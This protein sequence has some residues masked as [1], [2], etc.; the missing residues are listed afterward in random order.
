MTEWEYAFLQ[1]KSFSDNRGGE[2]QEITF[3]GPQGFAQP[4]Q[5]SSAIPILNKF[6]K[7]G[8]EAFYIEA[9]QYGRIYWLKRPASR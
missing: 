3:C 7:D 2:Y 6:G 8:W 5:A 4:V 9:I 1:A